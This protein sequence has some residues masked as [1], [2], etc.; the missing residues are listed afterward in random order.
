[1]TQCQDEF[2]NL[3]GGLLKILTACRML[4][5]LIARCQ[6]RGRCVFFAFQPI[7]QMQFL[8]ALASLRAMIEINSL[9]HVFEIASIRAL[10]C[11]RLL[12]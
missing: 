2:R 12:H 10:P 6:E 4:Q 9:I 8:D 11:S 5:I 1:M 3:S 7:A